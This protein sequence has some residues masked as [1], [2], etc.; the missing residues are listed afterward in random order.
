MGNGAACYTT[1]CVNPGCESR[2]ETVSTNFVD[3]PCV[4]WGVVLSCDFIQRIRYMDH[5]VF[6][7][8][9]LSVR[10]N[11]SANIYNEGRWEIRFTNNQQQHVWRLPKQEGSN[12]GRWTST[13]STSSTN[14]SDN[15][16]KTH[17]LATNQYISFSNSLEITWDCRTVLFKER[18]WPLSS[19]FKRERSC[20]TSLTIYIESHSS[21][22][23]ASAYCSWL[24][25]RSYYLA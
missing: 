17:T 3:I 10:D 12:F 2:W 23:D 16:K 21:I 9:S 6:D 13:S 24:S 18:D 11:F 5:D 22:H 1:C 19:N 8:D 4:S 14:V 7:L 20:H 15:P 25:S